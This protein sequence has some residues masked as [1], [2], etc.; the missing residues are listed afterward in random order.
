MAA[1]TEQ[2]EK[3]ERDVEATMDGGLCRLELPGLADLEDDE[4]VA[5]RHQREDG[6]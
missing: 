2:N 3:E 1:D 4:V 6:G 5:P